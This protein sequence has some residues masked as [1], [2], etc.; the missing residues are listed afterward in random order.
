MM[1][2]KL[3]CCGTTIS[4]V[5]EALD[6]AT[7]LIREGLVSGTSAPVQQQTPMKTLTLTCRGKTA[8]DMVA[9][10][11]KVRLLVSQGITNGFDRRSAG[12]FLFKVQERKTTVPWWFDRLLEC[13]ALEIHP[14]QERADRSCEPCT[15]EEAD[16]WSVYGHLTEGGVLCLEDFTTEAKAR[17]FAETLLS[18]WPWLHAHGIGG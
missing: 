5:I 16:F 13:D 2:L 1:I 8:D 4:D 18:A 7:R 11:K 14:V 17:A 12:G 9:A 3:T 15:P 6:D 10:L